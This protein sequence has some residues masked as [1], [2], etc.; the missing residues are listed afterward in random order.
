M[1]IFDGQ[2]VGANDRT[3]GANGANGTV[4][5][6]VVQLVLTTVP[7]AGKCRLGC[8]QWCHR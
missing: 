4:V 7:L 5:K 6:I 2:F 8:Y 1:N 3:N